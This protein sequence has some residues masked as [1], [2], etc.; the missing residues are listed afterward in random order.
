MRIANLTKKFHLTTPQLL[1]IYIKN[2]FN[3]S[4]C[5]VFTT[6]LFSGTEAHDD[7]DS[8]AYTA[9]LN[10]TRRERKRQVISNHQTKRPAQKRVCKGKPVVFKR[11]SSTTVLGFREKLHKFSSHFINFIKCCLLHKTR[12]LF[13]KHVRCPIWTCGAQKIFD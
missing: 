11:G 6:L 10:K 13:K 5:V 7:T 3:V 12:V 9:N 2:T 8:Q 4:C 1:Q